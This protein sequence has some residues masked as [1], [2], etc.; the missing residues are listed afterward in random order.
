MEPVSA[1]SVVLVMTMSSPW[2]ESAG[3]DLG[4]LPVLGQQEVVE[5]RL[6]LAEGA[7]AAVGLEAGDAGED[8]LDPL[9]PAGRSQ[10]RG[11]GD[12][13]AVHA[14]EEGL[15][16][17]R[18]GRI[19]RHLHISVLDV[20]HQERGLLRDQGDVLGLRRLGVVEGAVGDLPVHDGPLVR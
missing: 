7:V 3:H 5:A 6:L 19:L 9:L 13:G 1:E 20:D 15:P 12:N 17:R 11:V 18:L 16:A 8:H 4:V 10:G 14:L 2:G